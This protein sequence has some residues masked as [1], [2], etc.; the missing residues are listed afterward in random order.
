M[1]VKNKEA[2]SLFVRWEVNRHASEY[3]VELVH[4]GNVEE[5]FQV[6][7]ISKTDITIS[8]LKKGE[9]YGVRVYAYVKDGKQMIYSDF[10]SETRN[11]AI[12]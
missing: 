5:A 11:I 1:A 10:N 12:S 9:V 8:D 4:G 2:G 7:D 3:Y 6:D